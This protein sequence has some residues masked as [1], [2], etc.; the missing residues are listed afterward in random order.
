MT[1][2]SRKS[3]Q[4]DII[5]DYLKQNRKITSWYAIQ[6]FGITRLADIIHR[7]K[8]DGHSISKTMLYIKMRELERFQ[9]SQSTDT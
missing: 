2:L 5:L 4:K 3:S 7:L 6:E 8:K 9:L 1:Y